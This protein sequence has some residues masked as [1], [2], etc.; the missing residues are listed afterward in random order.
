MPRVVPARVRGQEPPVPDGTPVPLAGTGRRLAWVLGL[1]AF[2]Y[3]CYR[4]YYAA[5]GTFGM[6]GEPLSDVEFRVINAVG[7]AII[8]VAAVLPVV[9]V[10]VPGLRRALPVLGWLAAV[11][12]CTHALVNSTLRVLS[13][14][15]VHPTMLPSDVWRWYDRHVADLQ[16]LLLNEPWF[17]V[18]G[19]LWAAFGYMF[20]AASRRRA[21]VLSA[22]AA[23]LAL[24]VVGVLSG[25]DVIGS[26][27]IG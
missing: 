17:L 24:T 19:L 18:E 20:V 14:T 23:C 3:A 16:D 7:A 9:A 6:I 21:W 26:F 5:G 22:A 8:L 27:R 10:R 11:G 15:G 12:C 4:A 1:W 2:A 13:L 25:L